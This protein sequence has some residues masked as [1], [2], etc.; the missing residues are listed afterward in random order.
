MSNEAKSWIHGDES[1]KQI[2]ARVARKRPFLLRPPLHRVP[3]RVGNVV[4]IVG[5]SPSAKTHVLMQ[6][7]ISCILPNDWKGIHY[8]GLE[9]LVMYFDLDCRFD[10]E[11]FTQ[12]L[13]HCIMDCNGLGNG[14]LKKHGILSESFHDFEELFLSCMRRFSYVRCYNS[15]EFLSTLK[16]F[17]CHL[18]KENEKHG[19]GASFLMIDSISAFYW[20]DRATAPFPLGSTDRKSFSLNTILET[21]VQEIQRLF[22]IQPMLLFATKATISGDGSLTSELK[23]KR[24]LSNDASE[25]EVLKGFQK[26]VYRE[27]MPSIWQSFVTHRL[28]F[29]VSDEYLDGSSC[30]NKSIFQFEWLLPSL[31]VFEKFEVTDAGIFMLT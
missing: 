12:L 24:G 13:K 22:K 4:E 7:A 15:L 29:Q 8:G 31:N 30:G 10:V 6:A 28:R 5:P 20:T 2:L 1:A 11:R 9:S 16:T 14:N 26:D 17:R 27:Y 18:R 21:V 3:L 25:L 23:R 19:V